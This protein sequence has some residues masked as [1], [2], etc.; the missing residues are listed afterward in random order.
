MP[1]CRECPSG[2]EV[3]RR[4]ARRLCVEHTPF[5]GHACADCELVYFESRDG[6]LL[7]LWF[8]VGFALPWLVLATLH[9]SLPSS[10]RATG[11]RGMSTGVPLIDLSIM[12]MVSAVLLGTA[13][14]GLRIWLHRR[15]FL[16]PART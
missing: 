9:G 4:C 7:N 5:G 13:T 6:L 2:Q 14:R 3:C 10:A 8:L 12:T 1:S 11:F 15:A 16:A